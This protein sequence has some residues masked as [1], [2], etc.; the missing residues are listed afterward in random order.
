[1]TDEEK[2]KHF[3]LFI[4]HLLSLIPNKDYVSCRKKTDYD[5]VRRNRDN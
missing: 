1:M 5:T 3:V 2:I 4:P